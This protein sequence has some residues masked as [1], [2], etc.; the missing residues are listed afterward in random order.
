MYN[1]SAWLIGKPTDLVRLE[2][3]IMPFASIFST[4]SPYRI[5]RLVCH[6]EDLSVNSS[7][8]HYCHLRVDN[9]LK[10]LL[11]IFVFLWN[12]WMFYIFKKR[13]LYFLQNISLVQRRQQPQPSGIKPRGSGN[14]LVKPRAN[15]PKATSA[16]EIGK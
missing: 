4:T 13:K 9:E 11:L 12:K 3:K 10:N 1:Y 15:I 2:F 5:T 14:N 6:I 8:I 7:L 16:P